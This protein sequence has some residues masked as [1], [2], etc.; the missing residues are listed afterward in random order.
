MA[1]YDDASW[2]YGGDFPK[3]LEN[4]RGATHIGMF[5]TWCID[6]DLV[7]EFQIEEAG[8]DI[9]KV[10]ERSMSGTEFLINNCDEKFTDEDLNEIGNEFTSAY[11]EDS[12]FS[13]LY[14]PFLKDYCALFEGEAK[15]INQV[16]ESVYH[17]ED[18]WATYA[19]VKS[20]ID[21]RFDEWKL[22]A[23]K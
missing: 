9:Q 4:E 10:R 12:P 19:L 6:N 18:S 20:V 5:L 11:Y 17:V 22:F 7:S 13:N 14:G 23:K 2:H 15:N 1:K 21:K 16:L 3:E 8:D